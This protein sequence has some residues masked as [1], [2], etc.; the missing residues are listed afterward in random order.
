MDNEG[1]FSTNLRPHY[2]NSSFYTFSSSTLSSKMSRNM[3]KLLHKLCNAKNGVAL[4]F[5]CQNEP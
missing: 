1:F 5:T 3:C 4:R 2:Q